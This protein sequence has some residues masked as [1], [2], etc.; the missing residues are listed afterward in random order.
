MFSARFTTSCLKPNSEEVL[1]GV[2]QRD[3]ETLKE[4]IERFNKEAA[5]VRNLEDRQRLFSKKDGLMKG[6][7]F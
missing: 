7:L 4:Y 5:S 1:R 3:N 6:S 2:R